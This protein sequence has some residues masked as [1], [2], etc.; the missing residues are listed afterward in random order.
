VKSDLA[1]VNSDNPSGRPRKPSLEVTSGRKPRLPLGSSHLDC[2]RQATPCALPAGVIHRPR[3]SER[4]IGIRVAQKTTI[5]ARPR[6][7]I[8]R[9]SAVTPFAPYEQTLLLD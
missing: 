2:L 9:I 6:P 4:I 8:W 5:G 7:T 3:R 1:D